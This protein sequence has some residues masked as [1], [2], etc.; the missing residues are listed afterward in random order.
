MKPK[1]VVP[2]VIGLGVG[3]FAVKMGID[4]VKRAKGTQEDT[5]AVLV[6]AKPIEVATTVT[7]QML[8]SQ[9]V[10]SSLVPNDAFTDLKALSGRVT[11][12]SIPAGIPIT[13]AMLAPPGAQP[14]LRAKIP[15]GYRAVSVSVTEESAVAGFITPGSRV[16]VSSVILGSASYKSKLILTNIEVGAV[17]Q[18]LSVIGS[19]SKSSR[20]SKSVTLFLKPEQ[21]DI[22]NSSVGTGKGKIRL[23]LRGTSSDPEESLFSQLLK[24]AF[25]KD[26]APKKEEKEEPTKPVEQYVVEVRR[27]TELERLAFDESGRLV[28]NAS[29]TPAV[30]NGQSQAV[31]PG[32]QPEPVLSDFT[33]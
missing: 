26:D 32:E 4:M 29:A 21:V 2:L 24:K 28:P 19:D 14:G 7:D 31:P 11:N 5:K 10:P 8:T 17:G 25:E 12:M 15:T 16:D 33:E 30:M 6:S 18:S 22:L 27:G 3:F 13:R 1:T 9:K 23:A 20:V